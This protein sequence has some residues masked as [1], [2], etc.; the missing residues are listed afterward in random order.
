MPPTLRPLISQADY[1]A[2]IALQRATWGDDFRELVPPAV[3]MI[4][5]KTGGVAGGAFAGDDLVGFVFGLSGLEDGTPIHWSHMLAVRPDYRDHG[6]GRRLK[7]WQ[8]DRVRTRGIHVM[9]WTFDPLVAR[10]AH[11]NFT[12][13][14]VTAREYVRD[15][16]GS[17]ETSK[18]DRLIG[19]DRLVVRWELETARRGDGETASVIDIPADIQGLKLQDPAAA[20]RWRAETRRQFEE[21]FARGWTVLGFERTADGGRYQVGPA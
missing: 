12:R 2:A 7:N 17:G 6:L 19:S 5:E 16:Y 11:L 18:T 8:A 1:D 4:A 13:L 14:G 9:Y 20:Q 21:A 10:N 3:M 15:L